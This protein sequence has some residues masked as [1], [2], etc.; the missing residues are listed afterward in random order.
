MIDYKIAEKANR[1]ALIRAECKYLNLS[2][3]QN[4]L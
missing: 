4:N 2:I 1:I 3:T